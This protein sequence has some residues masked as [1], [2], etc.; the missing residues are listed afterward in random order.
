MGMQ[1]A[2]VEKIR[3]KKADYVIG[4]KDNHPT[5]AADMTTLLNEGIHCVSQVS[6]PIC[7][8]PPRRHA[9]A[10]SSATCV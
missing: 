7:M 4:L 9:A 8:S 6:S 2:I 3:E 5:L 10:W 1:T